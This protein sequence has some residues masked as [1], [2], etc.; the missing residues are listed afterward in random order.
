MRAAR[1]YVFQNMKV[2]TNESRLKSNYLLNSRNDQSLLLGLHNLPPFFNPIGFVYRSIRRYKEMKGAKE[3][4][5]QS[6]EKLSRIL[7]IAAID[8]ECINCK[9]VYP[10]FLDRLLTRVRKG[11]EAR[12]L[13]IRQGGC[14]GS[15]W[16]EVY[17]RDV[18]ST[19]K[20]KPRC[21]QQ[22]L[23]LDSEDKV[24][25]EPSDLKTPHTKRY[26][27]SIAKTN[28]VGMNSRPEQS[29]DK[30]EVVAGK[31]VTLSE[32]KEGK[33][34]VLGRRGCTW[35]SGDQF[36]DVQLKDF[37][38][39]AEGSLTRLGNGRSRDRYAAEGER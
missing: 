25:T 17:R 30:Q 6:V 38:E 27:Y 13:K 33:R 11:V 29:S 5:L 8:I 2:Q 24:A 16:A 4:N 35:D 18:T 28:E 39:G 19:I 20:S 9:E 10:D 7:R 23:K 34:F 21:P 14:F 15:P 1:K 32:L 22:S 12:M 36:A 31:D 26:K 3:A 37:Y